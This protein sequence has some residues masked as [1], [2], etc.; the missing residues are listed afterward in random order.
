MSTELIPTFEGELDGTRQTL[1]NARDLHA[2]LEVGRDFPTW[3]Q[4]RLEKYDFRLGSDYLIHKSVGQVDGLIPQ[5]GGIKTD[6]IRQNGGIEN[7]GGDRKSFD[8]HLGL[9]VAKE[10]A[11]VENN[12]RGRQVRRYFIEMEKRAKARQ[13]SVGIL[14]QYGYMPPDALLDPEE[15]RLLLATR[16]DWAFINEKVLAGW[17]SAQIADKLNLDDSG[18]RRTI[19][20]QRLNGCL[21]PDPRKVA[22]LIERK[23]LALNQAAKLEV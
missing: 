13:P 20:R 8:Y 15:K 6:L 3:M 23:L 18:V 5:N 17:S 22:M 16:K 2:F 9:D 12:E 7:R 10:L 1:C 14:R 19:R 4:S 11:M 21:P